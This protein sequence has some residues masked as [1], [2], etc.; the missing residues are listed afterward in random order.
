MSRLYSR[1]GKLQ[2]DLMNRDLSEEDRETIED[3]IADLEDEI[4]QEDSEKYTTYDDE[5]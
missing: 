1:L 5:L 2:R 3:E 4:E